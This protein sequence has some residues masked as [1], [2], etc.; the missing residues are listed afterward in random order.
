MC[1][2]IILYDV[3][4]KWHRRMLERERGRER[5][6]DRDRDRE[7]HRERVLEYG[8]REIEKK[9]RR[10]K[11]RKKKERINSVLFFF[12][13][14]PPPPPPPF[15]FSFFFFSLDL[16]CAWILFYNTSSHSCF[17]L[18]LYN[19]QHQ[20][21]VCQIYIIHEPLNKISKYLLTTF[22]KYGRER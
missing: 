15:F 17:R 14:P 7:R 5:E 1:D 12:F 16:L 9:R 11:K 8:L 2:V 18:L 19:R 3:K 6:K 10:K 20:E 13:S 22:F 4:L 21:A